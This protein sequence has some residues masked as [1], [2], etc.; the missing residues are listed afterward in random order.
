MFPC[1]H[2]LS[3][4]PDVLFPAISFLWPSP[5]IPLCNSVSFQ[6]FLFQ[7][8]NR[9]SFFFLIPS[10]LIWIHYIFEVGGGLQDGGLSDQLSSIL[11][12]LFVQG[13]WCSRSWGL[14]QLP[15]QVCYLTWKTHQKFR[16]SAKQ[17]CF[18]KFPISTRPCEIMQTMWDTRLCEII[19][20]V[21]VNR[22]DH[23][24]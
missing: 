16:K 9:T 15:H 17:G 12:L 11:K 20:T 5:K 14:H 13:F 2:F 4:F 7:D 3:F 24:D 19:Q 18:S 8:C 23:T 1:S 22:M 6:F 10:L 21:W